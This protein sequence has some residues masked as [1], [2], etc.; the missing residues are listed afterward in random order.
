MYFQI[1]N[2]KMDNYFICPKDSLKLDCPF[3]LLIIGPMHSG[4]STFLSKYISRL[5]DFVKIPQT[6]N[7][8]II[9]VSEI[10][11]TVHELEDVCKSKQYGFRNMK[12]IPEWDALLNGS[13]V[14][15]H[16]IIIFEDCAVD[17]NKANQS[18]IKNFLFQ[19]RHKNFSI[20]LIT[21]NTNHAYAKKA[22]NIM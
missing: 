17:L 20:I 15:N 12:G 13:S 3:R 5:D 2:L 10:L 7:T 16:K 4:K 21:H 11:S 14:V 6:H 18:N 22:M 8:E 9:L 1:I 19:S